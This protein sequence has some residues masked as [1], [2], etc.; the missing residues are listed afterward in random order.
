MIYCQFFLSCIALLLLGGCGGGASF[1]PVVTAVK[2]QSLQYGRT[3]SIY[4]GGQS[5]RSSMVVKTNGFCSN[6]SFASSSTTDLLLLN[7][8]VTAVGDFD[9]SVESAEGQALYSTSL[10][11]PKPQVLVVT[12]Q[13]SITLELDP[14]AAPVT[15]DNFLSYIARGY[16]TGTLFHRV[17][18]GFVIQGGGFTSGMVKK[19]GQSPAIVLETNKGLSNL[20]GTVAMARTSIPNSA[21]SEFFINLVNNSAALDYRNAANPGYAVFG[22]VVQGM[23]VVDAIAAQATGVVSSFTDVPVADVTIS[24]IL[25]IK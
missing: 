16:Y 24:Q 12:G 9:F 15:V 2:V 5:L 7:C 3:A 14:S 17:I 4:I 11:V 6:Q 1:P 22:A 20:R 8:N 21:T 25:Q 19:T 23:E 18:A 13:G 10:T